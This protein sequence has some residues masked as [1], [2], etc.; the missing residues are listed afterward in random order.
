MRLFSWLQSFLGR[1]AWHEWR[2]LAGFFLAACGLWAFAELA[3]EVIEGET[4]A[5]D[6]AIL[7]SMRSA[8]DLADPVGPQWL[9]EVA[10]DI[11]ALGSFA[12]LVLL[13]VFV[14][15]YLI[16]DGKRRMALLVFFTVSAGAVLSW[17]LKNSF[18]RP[19]PDLVPHETLV[20]TASFPSGHSLMSAVV[21]LTLA[22]LVAR[23]EGGRRI[24]LYF[25][26][27]AVLITLLIG[28]TRIYL[29]VHWPTD[30]LAG[31]SLGGCWAM[32]CWA[33]ALIL[34]KEHRVESQQSNEEQ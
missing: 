31:W 1:T 18:S 20:F 26:V 22:A 5:F 4:H 12:V 9:E 7:L 13:M 34:Q 6:R 28:I 30:V 21:Y 16:I 3:D 24:R 33:L 10:R 15:G 23:A 8:H 27:S 25:V 17:L 29:G 11:T 14:L 19:R 2:A 32:L